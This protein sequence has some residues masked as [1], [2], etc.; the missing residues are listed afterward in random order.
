VVV[1]GLIWRGPPRH[2]RD[3][4]RQNIITPYTSAVLL[5]ELAGVLSRKKFA[6]HLAA[7][8]LTPNSIIA[9]LCCVSA[10]HRRAGNRPHCPPADPDDDD[11][12][13][14]AL[15]AKANLIANGDSD[16][17]SLH[18]FQKIAILKPSDAMQRI[19]ADDYSGAV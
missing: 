10:Y 15:A 16:L 1:S 7:R 13:A 2:L 14:C 8:N 5:D 19:L 3:L 6:A 17:L 9:R 18:P 11:V 12:I 4:A